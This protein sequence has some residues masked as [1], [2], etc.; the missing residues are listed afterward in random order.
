MADSSG[1]HLVDVEA[2]RQ[3][4]AR[5]F[6]Y[7]DTQDW[8]QFSRV[9][10]EDAEMDVS[11]DGAGVVRGA[12]AIV[13]SIAGALDGA[14]TVHQGTTPEIHVDGDEATGIWAMTDLIV[15]P[16]GTRLDGAGHYHERYRRV[17]G[18]WRIAW[19]RLTRLRR[20]FTPP[21]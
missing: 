4:K 12:R 14:V 21:G 11:A 6:R 7:L 2:I 17:G 1:T 16:D 5:Y 9:F 3:L 20:E 15:F 18:S 19:F 8:E 13:T 10:T